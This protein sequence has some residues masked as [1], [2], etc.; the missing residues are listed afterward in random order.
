MKLALAYVPCANFSEA[1]EI[2][3]ACLNKGLAVCCNILPSVTSLFP[4]D[5]Q[6]VSEEESLLLIKHL[7][8]DFSKLQE[9]IVSLHSYHT[10]CIAQI[11]LQDCNTSYLNWAQSARL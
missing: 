2:A 10:P 11:A 9:Y 1:K 4:S 7:P 6:V 3:R 5:G 8:D